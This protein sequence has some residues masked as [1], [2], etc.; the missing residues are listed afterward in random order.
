MCA[1]DAR[2]ASVRVFPEAFDVAHLL[3][4]RAD[5]FS[6]VSR[7]GVLKR[8]TCSPAT[9]AL[10]EEMALNLRTDCVLLVSDRPQIASALVGGEALAAGVLVTLR[11]NTCFSVCLRRFITT[12]IPSYLDFI[13]G[14]R[15]IG[16]VGGFATAH[17]KECGHGERGGS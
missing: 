15:A 10:R 3:V 13:G 7:R 6:V 11:P 17:R 16:S 2:K 5:G 1:I 8:A 12:D 9:L 14:R 4:D